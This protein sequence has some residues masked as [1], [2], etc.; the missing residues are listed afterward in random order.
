MIRYLGLCL[1]FFSFLKTEH[2]IAQNPPVALGQWRIHLP[3]SEVRRITETPS[4][5]YC[6]TPYGLYSYDKGDG[7]T[8][9]LSPINGFGGYR[10]QAM[11][12][13]PATDILIIAYSDCKIELLKGKT[14][15]GNDDIFNKTIIG[16]KTINHIN[17]VNGIAY[18][19]TS[20][21]LLE[22]NLTKNEIRNSYQNIGP[23]GSVLNIHASSVLND[24]LFISTNIGVLRGSMNPN[25]NLGISDNWTNIKAAGVQSTHIASHLN[26]IYT[27]VDSILYKYSNGTW[28][29]LEPD[30]R[31]ITNI[32]VDHGKLVA[33]VYGRYIITIDE[34]GNSSNKPINIL[35]D[36]LIDGNGQY[37]YASPIN[38]LSFMNPYGPE[39]YYYP[40]GPRSY[41]SFGITN[42]FGQLYVTAGGMRVTTYAPTFNGFKFYKFDN[43]EWSFMPDDPMTYPLYDFTHMA[44]SKSNNRLYTGT[45]GKGL[46][47]LENGLPKQ[48]WDETNSP[49]RARGNLYTIVNGLAVDGKNNVWVS[50]FGVDTGLHMVTPAGAWRSYKLPTGNTG[51]IVLDNKGNKWILTPQAS[52]IGIIA[53]K[54]NN[55]PDNLNDDMIIQLNSNKGS[56]NLPSN[57]VS[58]IAFSK[59]GELLIGTDQGYS[60][61]RVPSNAFNPNAKPGD[62]D[63]Q[64]VIISVEANSNLGGYLLGSEVIN[65]ITLDG[66]DRRWFG[67][68]TGAWLI[69]SDGETI[70]YHFTTDNS[71]LMSNN[72]TAIG[73]M[74][75]T[76][77]VFFC[78]DLGIASFRA[79]A[80]PA[81]KGFETLKIFPN[82]VKPD[83]GGDIGISGMPDNTLVKITDIN[84]NLVYQ[85]YS[86]GSLAVWNGKNFDGTRV[87]T[88]VY[89][90]FCINTE[91]T[92]T[93]V[94]KIL[95]IH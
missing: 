74:E 33:G 31:I 1:I 69:D 7:T 24:S 14:I 34:S 37:W 78:T 85:T 3:Y 10:V 43:F 92:E 81:Q 9:R 70:L 18:I 17:I 5:I 20:F 64:R 12:Y 13:D 83:Y 2:S 28:T 44:F 87:S 42:A 56:G 94:G 79:D 46:L 4:K 35:N 32:D 50:N 65:C 38:G 21:G 51:K 15:T 68:N 47:M 84:G 11:D 89:L 88:G 77:E 75:S 19:S 49:L 27:E 62:Y 58:D 67:T 26:S 29:Q 60:K 41:T 55:T 53:F 66:G 16:E 36:C 48:V 76:G 39:I 25:V 90:V 61:I 72:V 8:E 57:N 73:I 59:S 40:N 93:Q 6:A 91:G 95:F 86:N 71:P 30:K 80:M 23:G 52:G 22:F 45:H 63:A 54:D 82:P